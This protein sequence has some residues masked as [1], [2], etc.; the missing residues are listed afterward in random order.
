MDKV[1][2]EWNEIYTNQK[3]KINEIKYDDWLDLFIDDINRCDTPIIDLGCGGGNDTK[4]LTEKGKIV[5]PCDYSEKAIE[6]IKNNFHEIE[7]VECFDMTKVFPFTDSFTGIIIAD[8]SLHYFSEDTTYRVLENIKRILKTEGLLIFRVNSINDINHGAG[9][10][11]EIETHFYQTEDGR[12][13]RFFDESDIKRI[14]G[15]WDILYMRED[16]MFRYK[17]PKAL[18]ICAV[19][20]R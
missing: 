13:K 20:K 1:K 7:R 18:W 11:L 19:K 16:T 14:F 8:L 12:T 5:I 4:Y 9:E 15:N 3:H 17:Y 6:N 2:E 10:G